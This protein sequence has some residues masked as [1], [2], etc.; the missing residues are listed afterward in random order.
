M[1]VDDLYP[2]DFNQ[3]CPGLMRYSNGIMFRTMGVWCLEMPETGLVLVRIRV[4]YEHKGYKAIPV[5]TMVADSTLR[6][7]AEEQPIPIP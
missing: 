1:E 6:H 2:Q 7:I 5:R 4:S 3:S